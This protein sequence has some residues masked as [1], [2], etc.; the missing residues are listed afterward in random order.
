VL[1]IMGCTFD[2]CVSLDS[3][4]ASSFGFN[5]HLSPACRVTLR[6]WPNS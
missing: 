6:A 3:Q 4:M 2:W 5:G 1:E